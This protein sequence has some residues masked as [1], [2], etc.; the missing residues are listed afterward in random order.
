MIHHALFDFI[1]VQRGLL[2]FIT[3]QDYLLDVV[4]LAVRNMQFPASETLNTHFIHQVF[5]E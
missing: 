4:H 1:K 3:R 2:Q 5:P